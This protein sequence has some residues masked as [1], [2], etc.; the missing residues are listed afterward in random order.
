MPLGNDSL[1][2]EGDVFSRTTLTSAAS[3]NSKLPPERKVRQPT[4]GGDILKELSP[5]ES[6]LQKDPSGR[7]KRRQGGDVFLQEPHDSTTLQTLG[8]NTPNTSHNKAPRRMHNTRHLK[9]CTKTA[10]RRMHTTR[11]LKGCTSKHL[12]GYTSQGT[13]KD[14]HHNT[15]KDAYIKETRR[16]R[17]KSHYKGNRETH[18]QSRGQ[19]ML[20]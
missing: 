11:H 6:N 20:Q 4:K 14:A 15:S 1:G 16:I 13:S 8:A 2:R 10:P 19:N 17:N 12:E 3:D 7:K 9:G 5:V 18:I